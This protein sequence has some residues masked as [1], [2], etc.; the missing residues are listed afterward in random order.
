MIFIY[1]YAYIEALIRKIMEYWNLRTNIVEDYEEPERL[2]S[3]EYNPLGLNRTY[4][5]LIRIE[6]TKQKST[7]IH[8]EIEVSCIEQITNQTYLFELNKKQIYINEKAANGLNEE[9]A[10]TC[11]AVF[12][13]LQLLVNANNKAIFCL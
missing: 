5:V 10:E 11:G 6:D 2:F 13:P 4:G 8:F 1:A 7:Q 3:L 12:Y 9:F